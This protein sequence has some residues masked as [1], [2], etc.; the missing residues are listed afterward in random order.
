VGHAIFSAAAE[1][2]GITLGDFND[3]GPQDIVVAHHGNSN[4]GIFLN[5]CH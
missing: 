1:P 4:V 5:I 2:H 3:D